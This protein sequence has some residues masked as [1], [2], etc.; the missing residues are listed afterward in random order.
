HDGSG[1]NV[2][3]DV[4]SCNPHCVSF[5]IKD[6]NKVRTIDEMRERMRMRG[7]RCHLMYCRNATRLQV[8]PLLASRSQALRYLFVRW[9]LS[10]GN[11]YLIVGEHGDTDHEEML[12]GLHKTVII[13]GVTEKGS[14]QLVR[15]SGSYQREDVVP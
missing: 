7:L 14:E 3:P 11:M 15:S 10:V 4:E 6:P 8:V 13:R 12:S 5:F 9:G 2:E 1:T